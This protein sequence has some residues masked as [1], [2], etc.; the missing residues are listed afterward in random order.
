MASPEEILNGLGIT[1]DQAKD[2]VS[3]SEAFTNALPQTLQDNKLPQITIGADQAQQLFGDVTVEDVT[4][5][6]HALPGM[7]HVVALTNNKPPHG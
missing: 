4:A 1:A 5:F 7:H 3:Q 6:Y 2:Y